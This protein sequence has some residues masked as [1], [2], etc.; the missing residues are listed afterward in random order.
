MYGTALEKRSS[1]GEVQ[2][3]RYGERRDKSRQA[4]WMAQ[5]VLEG[6]AVQTADAQYGRTVVSHGRKLFWI[7]PPFI[8]LQ[9][10]GRA[11]V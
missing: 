11:H 9:E 1:H 10:I 6:A 8:L 4:G 5:T 7:V 2:E 3:E